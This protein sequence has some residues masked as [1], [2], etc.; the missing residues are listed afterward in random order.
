MGTST[1]A[2][3][4]TSKVIDEVRNETL[5]ASYTQENMNSKSKKSKRNVPS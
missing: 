1:S 4:I 5:V 2:P 3:I